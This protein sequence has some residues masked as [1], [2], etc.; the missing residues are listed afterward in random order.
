M[1]RLNKPIN[2]F[3]LSVG[4]DSRLGRPPDVPIKYLSYEEERI[5]WSLLWHHLQT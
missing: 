5:P 2:I 1:N 4:K 3:Y